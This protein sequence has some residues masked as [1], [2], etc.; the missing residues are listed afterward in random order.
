MMTKIFNYIVYSL[1]ITVLFSFNFSEVS[2]AKEP[3]NNQK[4]FIGAYKVGNFNDSS[5]TSL[6]N[7]IALDNGNALIFGEYIQEFDAKTNKFYKYKTTYTP[8]GHMPDITI[9]KNNE[10][11]ILTFLLDP[12]VRKLKT[13]QFVVKEYNPITK[14]YKELKN[15]VIDSFEAGIKNAIK[16][17]ENKVFLYVS[18]G[19]YYIYDIANNSISKRMSF[20]NNLY[21]SYGWNTKIGIEKLDNGNFLIFGLGFGKKDDNL[22]KSNY[23]FEYSPKNN[24]IKIVG[25]LVEN[26]NSGVVHSYRLDDENII[27]FGGGVQEKNNSIQIKTVEK[28]NIKNG[29][30]K[31]IGELPYGVHS[32]FS[33]GKKWIFVKNRGILNAEKVFYDFKTNKFSK[34]KYSEIIKS[35]N[36]I[37]LELK[38]GSIL[39]VGGIVY[40]RYTK[41]AYRYYWE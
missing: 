13:S 11:S 37:L 4:K 28:Y 21:K 7:A 15:I 39:F 6:Y 24:N 32:L 30:S 9:V 19:R 27:V 40:G 8:S 34:L 38:D 33:I 10:K 41:K 36:P 18:N 14:E 2:Y 23:V 25:E 31:I 3:I 26:R 12:D 16:L 20:E 35:E 17:D 1:L 29:T 5:W 22:K